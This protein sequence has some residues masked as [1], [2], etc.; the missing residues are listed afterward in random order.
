MKN[1]LSSNVRKR[2]KQE[3]K[4]VFKDCRFKDA[5]TMKELDINTPDDF[6]YY[7]NKSR[8]G[9]VG[10]YIIYEIIS[11][12]AIRRADNVVIE[13][14]VFL[15]VDIFSLKSFESKLLQETI[16][17]LEEKLVTAGF[18][19]EVRD[20]AFESGTK[21]YHQIFFVSKLYF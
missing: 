16:S 3:I 8:D 7:Y 17:K 14:E 13:R 1:I 15:Q 18:E 10:N 6:V 2:A 5:L 12:D 21:L 4:K 20:E 11:S 9:E 19:V